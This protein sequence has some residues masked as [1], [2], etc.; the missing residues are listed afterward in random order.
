MNW[1]LA[2]MVYQII[3]GSGNHTP[4]F[5]EQLRLIRADEYAWAR[6]KASIVGRLLE[7]HL[8]NTKDEKVIWRFVEVTELIQLPSLEDGDEIYSTTQE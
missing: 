4:Q 8:Q 3:S 7:Q 6:E 2:K 1:Y 5:D